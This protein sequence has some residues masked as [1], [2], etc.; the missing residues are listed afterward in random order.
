MNPYPLL[1]PVASMTT[2]KFIKKTKN[3]RSI[4]FFEDDGY[5]DFSPQ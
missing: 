2:N 4:N 3:K 1:S 5:M